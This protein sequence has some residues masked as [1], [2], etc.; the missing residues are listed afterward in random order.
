MT[1]DNS[2]S[3]PASVNDAPAPDSQEFQEKANTV[4]KVSPDTTADA[5]ATDATLIS[6]DP[7]RSDASQREE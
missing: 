4:E 3:S 6:T 5:V 2:S 7:T 1:N